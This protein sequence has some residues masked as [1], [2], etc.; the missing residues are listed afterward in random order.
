MSGNGAQTP[1][2]ISLHIEMRSAILDRSSGVGL[3]GGTAFGN[4]ADTIA[5]D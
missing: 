2:S 4:P 5:R 3:D 1:R